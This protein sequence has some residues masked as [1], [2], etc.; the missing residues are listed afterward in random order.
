[1]RHEDMPKAATHDTVRSVR[2]SPGNG[3][4]VVERRN[5]NGTRW[6]SALNEAR[7]TTSLPP[8]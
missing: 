5:D 1:Q 7:L 6:A 3:W 4:R 8:Q 2:A